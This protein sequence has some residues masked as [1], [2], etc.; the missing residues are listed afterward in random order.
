VYRIRLAVKGADI[1]FSVTHE[2]LKKYNA[3]TDPK[4]FI[5]HGVQEYFIAE[6][7]PYLI[8]QPMRIG[9]SANILRRDI[10]R[11][12]LIQIIE[13]NQECVVDFWGSYNLDQANIGGGLDSDPNRFIDH[14][15]NRKNIKMHGA[16]P[17]PELAI[18]LREIDF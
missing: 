2:M 9:F 17:A 18:A 7:K 6:A 8:G 15:S 3:Y 16:I 12:I 5:N 13:E 4:H 11:D 10:D 1:V 14:H